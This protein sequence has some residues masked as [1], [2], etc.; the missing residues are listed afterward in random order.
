M[1]SDGEAHAARDAAQKALSIMGES[2]Q[3]P[4]MDNSE[5]KSKTDC[6]RK[7]EKPMLVAPAPF[8]ASQ[9]DADEGLE[10]EAEEAAQE[11]APEPVQPEAASAEEQVQVGVTRNGAAVARARGPSAAFAAAAAAAKS[12]APG[13]P[14]PSPAKGRKRR[15]SP[16][17]TPHAGEP[18]PSLARRRS[19]RGAG[20][21]HM[22]L[23]L[24]G[25][26]TPVRYAQRV[27]RARLANQARGVTRSP[28]ILGV[29]V[30]PTPTDA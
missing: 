9:A 24:G 17:L 18:A 12:E 3:P 28:A 10:E 15:A 6:H 8:E 20:E 13:S 21:G 19:L 23:Q 11:E 14:A 2:V 30:A 27:K 1:A 26:A 25:D 22:E 29:Q 7:V 5:V 16:R 4:E